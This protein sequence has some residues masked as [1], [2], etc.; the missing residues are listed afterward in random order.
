MIKEK[1]IDTGIKKLWIIIWDN[2]KTGIN[3]SSYP[4]RVLDTN[5]FTKPG[6]IIK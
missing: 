2:V 3:T 6:D 5:M 1:L 4:G